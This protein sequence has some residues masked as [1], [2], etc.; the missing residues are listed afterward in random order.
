MEK[1][2][3]PGFVEELSTKERIKVGVL[4]TGIDSA[5][6]DLAGNY[7]TALSYDFV[8]DKSGGIDDNGHGTEVAGIIGARVNGA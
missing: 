6:P 5:H 4:D 3:V 2:G 1:V 7:D 8:A